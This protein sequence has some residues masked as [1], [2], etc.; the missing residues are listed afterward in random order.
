MDRQ[1]V[2]LLLLALLVLVDLLLAQALIF[3][4]QMDHQRLLAHQQLT[5]SR[6]P[7]LQ[8]LVLLQVLLVQMDHCRQDQLGH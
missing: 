6:W 1:L 7:V 8:L 4:L 5:Q 2:Q 3:V